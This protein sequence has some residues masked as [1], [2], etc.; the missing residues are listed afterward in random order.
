MDERVEVF[1]SFRSPYSWMG[2]HRLER[3]KE[4]LPGITLEYIPVFPPPGAPEPVISADPRRLNYAFEDVARFATAY[5]LEIHQ[6]ATRDTVWM[7]PHAAFL[8]ARDAGRAAAFIEEAYRAR[9][10]HSCDLADDLVLAGVAEAAGLA[11]GLV[12]EA[13]DSP[14]RHDQV[15]AGLLDFVKLGL[16]GVPAFVFRGQRFWG[17]DRLEWLVRAVDQAAGRPVTDL[18]SDPLGSPLRGATPEPHG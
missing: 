14:A 2:C 12:L 10:Q 17:N 5:G 1:F 8:A 7:R 15:K 13:A 9:F 11:P 3:V 6:P 4:R 16:F 18:C